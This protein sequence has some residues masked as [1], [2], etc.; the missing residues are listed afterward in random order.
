MNRNAWNARTLALHSGDIAA[1]DAAGRVMAAEW[2]RREPDTKD[3]DIVAKFWLGRDKAK[4]AATIAAINKR[5][6]VAEPKRW[7]RARSVPREKSVADLMRAWR[8]AAGLTREQAGDRLGLGE[9]AIR[10][11]EQGLRR[12]DDVLTQIALKKL[13]G[14]EK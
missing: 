14:D 4:D 11:I 12:A 2:S 10:D 6:R 9:M 13:L 3:D 7:S 5:G 8:A 1:A